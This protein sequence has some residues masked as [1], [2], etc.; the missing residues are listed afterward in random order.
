MKEL[1]RDR[2]A[3]DLRNAAQ[4]ADH[5][6][7]IRPDAVVLA[8]A[9]VGGIMANTTRP[10]E[11]IYD[12][13]MIHATVVARGHLYGVDK[14]LYL[15]SSCIYPRSSRPSRSPR[16]SCYR[17]LEPTNEPYADR[18]DRG[19]QAVPVVPPPVR[20]QLHLGDADQPLRARRQ[21]RSR[22]PATCC[23]R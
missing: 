23:R 21:L 14:L 16:T 12:N 5:L 22:H 18:E 7:N 2:A 17:P 20:V 13:L 6:K 11:F 15:G 8:A 10:A 19:H 3:L 4:T 1:T 9:K